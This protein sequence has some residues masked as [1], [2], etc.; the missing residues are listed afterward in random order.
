[1]VVVVLVAIGGACTI[2]L[3]RSVVEVRVVIGGDE[4]QPASKAV[5]PSNAMPSA[6]P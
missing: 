5:P 3:V 1:V 4:P 6:K 2:V